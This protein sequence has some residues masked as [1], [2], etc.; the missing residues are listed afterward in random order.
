MNIKKLSGWLLVTCWI[1]CYANAEIIDNKNLTSVKIYYVAPIVFFQPI[2]KITA[3]SI[4]R[5]IE[6][7]CSDKKNPSN[8]TKYGYNSQYIGH[9]DLFELIPLEIITSSYYV[10][11]ISHDSN[12]YVV[13]SCFSNDHCNFWSTSN[14]NYNDKEIQTFMNKIGQILYEGNEY[15]FQPVNN[16]IA[17][18]KIIDKKEVTKINI[19]SLQP[20]PFAETL[21]M[22]ITPDLIKKYPDLECK[23]IKGWHCFKEGAETQYRGHHDIFD[24][25]PSLLLSNSYFPD[26]HRKYG[27]GGIK[28][29]ICF[30]DGHCNLWGDDIPDVLNRREYKEI[31]T[32]V[33]NIRKIAFTNDSK[34]KFHVTN[35]K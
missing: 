11:P 20:Y 32:Y 9:H 29:K 30:T 1:T 10:N 8:C 21:V 18:T 25:L 33:N 24:S 2:V 4:I 16:F 14:S 26:D 15:N 22:E 23:N 5:Y 31:W 13:E 7:R 27:E 3:N 34:Y 19:Y 12:G 6:Y 17:N 35:K 28:I